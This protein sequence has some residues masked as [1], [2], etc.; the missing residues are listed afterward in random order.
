MH[1]NIVEP[2]GLEVTLSHKPIAC[3]ISK[4]TDTHSEFIILGAF[5]LQQWLQKRAWAFRYTYIACLVVL[6][7]RALSGSCANW[8]KLNWIINIFLGQLLILIIFTMTAVP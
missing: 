3:C 8:N 4:A 1:K 7:I 5:P 2:D 6:Y